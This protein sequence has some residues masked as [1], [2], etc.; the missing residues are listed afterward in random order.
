MKRK[1]KTQEGLRKTRQTLLGRMSGLFRGPQVSE[2]DWEGVEEALISADVGVETTAELVKKVRARLKE[3]KPSSV[4]DLLEIFRQEML[5]LFPSTDDGPGESY[6]GDAELPR[7]LVVLVVGVNGVGKTTSI[8]KLAHRFKEQ[9]RRVVLA[10]GDTFRAA[11]IEQ[12]Q[13]WGERLDVPVVAHQSGADPGAVAY[14]AYQAAKARGADVLIV[15][16]AGRMHTRVNLMEELRKVRRVLGR[17]DPSAPHQ[18]LLVLDATTGHNGLAQAR[19]FAEA[20]GITGVFLA[21]LDGTAKGGIVLAVARELGI[22][23]QFIGTGE[24]LEDMS[25]FDADDFLDAMLTPAPE[26][27]V[28]PHV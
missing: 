28:A 9:G 10:A 12:L 22:P 7:P 13:R 17:L 6:N 14:D 27:G 23:V 8:A 18:V 11:A 4:A 2:Q 1:D 26:N 5:R 3:E 16:T 24:G 25:T 19:S 20:V 21:K 15:D